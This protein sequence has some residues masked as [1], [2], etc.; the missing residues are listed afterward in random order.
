MSENSKQVE[1][2]IRHAAT[3]RNLDLRLE[4]NRFAVAHK[5]AHSASELGTLEEWYVACYPDLN[6][7]LTRVHDLARTTA[8]STHPEVYVLDV[9]GGECLAVQFI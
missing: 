4:K 2:E 7:G 8:T 6:T 5:A 9:I 3:K 1:R